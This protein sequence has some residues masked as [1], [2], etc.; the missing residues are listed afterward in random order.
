MEAVALLDP[1]SSGAPLIEATTQLGYRAIGIF[2]QS[3]DLYPRLYGT[4]LDAFAARCDE[5]FCAPHFDEVFSFLQ[6]KRDLVA[7]IPATEGGVEWAERLA[8]KLHLRGNPIDCVSIR[9]DKGRMRQR[10]REAKL[11]CPDYALCKDL[12]Q[13]RAFV[14]AHSFPLV[15]KTPRSAATN[16]VFVCGSLPVIE[17]KFH[18]IISRPN[19]YRETVG[20]VLI[21]EY[22]GG[23]EYVVDVFCDGKRLHVTDCWVYEK[24][25]AEFAQNL[26]YNTFSLPLDDPKTAHIRAYG[27]KVA[28]VFQIHYGP[29][30]IEIKDDPLRGPTMVEIGARL[31][32]GKIPSLIQHA[33]NFDP[34]R[35]TVEVFA[36]GTTEVPTPIMYREHCALVMCPSFNSGIVRSIHGIE[37]I[38]A[39][40]SYFTHILTIK[41]G[42]PLVPSVTFNFDPLFV[43]LSHPDRQQIQADARAVHRLFSVEWI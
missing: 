14:A 2:C 12:A 20:E 37:E 33:T 22:I 8:Q 7:V 26:Y 43:F 39:L 21:E 19:L 41:P 10:L 34:F 38:Q 6:G 35:A 30:H 3:P 27:L 24:I 29:A 18:Q 4:T 28:E 32:G 16:D 1:V 40:P 25:D 23:H 5:A 36:R 9:R 15:L 11:S 17:E 31:A 13:L 42:D